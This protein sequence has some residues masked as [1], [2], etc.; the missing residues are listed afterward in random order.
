MIRHRIEYV[1]TVG[2]FGPIHHDHVVIVS[3]QVGVNHNADTFIVRFLNET[4]EVKHCGPA[5]FERGMLQHVFSGFK[6]VGGM[7]IVGVAVKREKHIG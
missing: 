4:V 3:F 1:T 7:F 5:L 2:Q 6:I